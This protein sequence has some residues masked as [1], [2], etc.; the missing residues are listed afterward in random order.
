MVETLES[1]PGCMI[2]R[3]AIT[4]PEST[5]KSRLTAELAAH[6]KT[7]VVHE[8]A[9]EYPN[10]LIRPQTRTGILEIAQ[11][12]CDLENVAP[13]GA[14]KYLFVDTDFLVT[15][16]WSEFC[17]KNCP[18][19]IEEKFHTH[20]Y[21]LY[22]LCDVDLPWE[23]DPLREHPLDGG[24]FFDW[25]YKELKNNKLPFVVI[26]GSGD[27]RT[28]NAIKAITEYFTDQ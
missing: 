23:P 13:Q 8:Y 24:F 22:L 18:A 15:K 17:Y 20:R 26:R 19:W 12:Q 10:L 27:I 9:P 4:G 16:I 6:F 21:D 2:R 5:G 25:F 7:I 14:N 1:E 11:N 3:I 28:H